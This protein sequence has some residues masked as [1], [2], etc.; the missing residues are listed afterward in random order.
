MGPPV[1]SWVRVRVRVR[2][3]WDV[4]PPVPSWVRDRV[5]VRVL[6]DVGPPVPSWVRDRVRVLWDVGPPVSSWA[7]AVWARA[8]GKAQC[9]RQ[10]GIRGRLHVMIETR[11][12]HKS[13]AFFKGHHL[14]IHDPRRPGP[15]DSIAAA[16][17]PKH[18]L[19][20]AFH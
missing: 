18:A 6:W 8:D 15:A 3:L 13:V 1:P 16:V 2:V 5:R 12:H 4:G 10:G 20:G 17:Q 7:S 9:D 11:R 14:A 19:E